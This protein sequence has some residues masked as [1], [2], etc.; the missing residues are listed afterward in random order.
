M[1]MGEEGEERAREETKKS[2]RSCK[3][4]LYYSS[5]RKS[6]GRNPLCVGVSRT[7]KQVPSYIGESEME[8]SKEGRTLADFK[9]A[10]VGYSVHLN[11]KDSSTD[12]KER[13]AELPFC[14][15]IEIVISNYDCCSCWWIKEQQMLIMLMLLHGHTTGKMI[16]FSLNHDNTNRH[17]PLGRN[18]SA[19]LLGML[20]W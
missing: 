6:Q 15:G 17:I 18:S 19:G 8:A 3:G 10:C 13:E 16:T 4:C 2:G 12:P 5:L 7:L 20:V 1:S 9:Y 14:V 11:N